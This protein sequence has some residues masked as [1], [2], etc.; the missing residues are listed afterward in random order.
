MTVE[1][2]WRQGGGSNAR[3]TQSA[4]VKGPELTDKMEPE[5]GRI[6]KG[7]LGRKAP[8]ENS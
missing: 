1:S 3:S 6:F 4:V 2:Q 7:L 5:A 8:Y